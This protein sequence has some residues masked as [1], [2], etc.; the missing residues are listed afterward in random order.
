MIALRLIPTWCYWLL[1]LIALCFG[2]EIHGRHTVQAKWDKAEI[3]RV[4]NEKA[5]IDIRLESN[6][7]LAQA[8]ADTTTRISDANHKAI[9]SVNSS[10]DAARHAVAVTGGLRVAVACSQV[11]GPAQAG[12]ASGS[13]GTGTRTVALPDQVTSDLLDL[14]AEADKVVE[15]L[16]SAQDFIKS[17][18]FAP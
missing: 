11:A 1:A 9:A 8:Q 16:R 17:N 14:A 2:F 4:A 15:Q 5:Q 10:L 13:N 3:I 6:R 12:S 7:M 18:G